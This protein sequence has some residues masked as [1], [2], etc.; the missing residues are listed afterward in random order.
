MRRKPSS[1][2]VDAVQAVVFR[3]PNV[4]AVEEVPTP[5]VKPHEVLVRVE[6]AGVCGTDIHL[7]EGGYEPKY[8]LIPGHEF[9]GVVAE[10]GSLVTSCKP[11]DR[12]T[13][14]PNLYCDRCYYC[15]R[16]MQNHCEAWEAIGVTLPG[17]FAEYVAVP[18]ASVH[19]I[20]SLDFTAGAFVEPLAC[21]VYGQRRARV[22][23]GDSV[24]IHGA[25]PIGLLHL[26]MA[27]H[28]GCTNV[29]VTD[30]RTERLELAKQLGADYVLHA[31]Q[32]DVDR[33]LRDIE[34]RGFDLVI[35]A[36]GV[37]S[38]VEEALRHVKT[39][40]RFLLFGVCPNESTIRWS[41]YEIY[42]RDL[43]IIGA[44][45][46]RKTFQPAI[47][48]LETKAIQVTP[49]VGTVVGLKELPDALELMR[50]GQA[51]MKIH[52]HPQLP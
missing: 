1:Q 16:D 19:G 22:R 40:G 7:M 2:G 23:M 24:L 32:G 42:R 52:V 5:S 12:V 14:D 37:P 20:G 51:P 4:V 46:L 10:V 29:T 49:L 38:V 21:V 34:P 11:G 13:V 15:R 28:S 47:E 33:A 9:S 8:P 30:L 6:A 43:E 25:G 3:K 26:Q 27:K 31:A 39:G 36:T 45:A 35:D 44:F 17:A 50:Q 48:L 41:P 18:E